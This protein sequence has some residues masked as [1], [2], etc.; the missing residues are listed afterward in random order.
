MLL[1]KRVSRITGFKYVGLD[2]VIVGMH[3]FGGSAPANELFAEFGFTVENVV[4][5]AKT[6]LN[7]Q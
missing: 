3:S 4:T 2:G 1:L 6:L 5:Q 7:N